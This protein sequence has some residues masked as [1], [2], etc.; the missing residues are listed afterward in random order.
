MSS[1]PAILVVDD[2]PDVVDSLVHLLRFDY[3]VFGATSAP[4]ALEIFARE[5]LQVILSDQRMPGTTG[6]ELL[7]RC[8]RDKPDVTRLLMTGYADVRAVIDAINEGKVYRYISKPWDPDELRTV[9]REG[10]ARGELLAERRRLLDELKERNRELEIANEELRQADEA[11]TAFVK[12]A[13]HELRTPLTILTGLT[14]LAIRAADDTT[15]PWLERIQEAA[16][17]LQHLVDQLIA[18]LEAGR[19]ERDRDLRTVDVGGL[20]RQAAD[21][22][23]VFVAQRKQDFDVDAPDELG[24]LEA[25]ATMLRDCLNHLLLNAIKFTPDGGRI[26]LRGQRSPDAITLEIS[27]TGDGV[28]A[29][30]LPRLFDPFF[31]SHDVEHHSSGQ[32][33]YGRRGL[34]LGLSVVK[35][36]VEMHGGRIDVASTLGEGTTFTIA[37]PTDARS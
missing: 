7:G 22:V 29:E 19:R 8:S 24:S 11:R 25:D 18:M 20:L 28:S 31:T 12:V 26:R 17:R 3:K 13:S 14:D 4:E 16:G 10:V 30:A 21:D 36:L 33:E 35:A 15:A 1:K 2:E 9:I 32:F 6:V 34:G 5:E 27:D 23:A 37:L